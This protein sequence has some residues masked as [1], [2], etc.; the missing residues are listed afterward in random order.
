MV[1]EVK[2]AGFDFGQCL[3][4]GTRER[5]YWMIGDMSKELGE[6][7]LVDE[8][9]HRWRTLKEKYGGYGPIKARHR[10]EIISYIFNDRPKAKDVFTNIERGYFTLEGSAIDTI[11]HLRAQNIEVSIV[12]EMRTTLGGIGSDETTEFLKS[13][14]LLEYF[15]ELISTQGKVNLRTG[16]LDMEYQGSAKFEPEGT[17]Y[18]ILAKDLQKRGIKP[19]EAVMIGDTPGSDIHPAQK[20]GFK[21]IQYVGFVNQGPSRAEFTIRQFSELKDILKGVRQ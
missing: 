11:K 1:M 18:D 19:S 4:H 16:A 17:L 6:P 3:M 12:S 2:W 21:A 9:C 15:D 8:R 14:N 20:R 13:R 5:T 10:P 7:E